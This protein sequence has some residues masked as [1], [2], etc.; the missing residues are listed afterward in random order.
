MD[1]CS[2]HSTRAAPALQ[3]PLLR[4]SCAVQVVKVDHD[5]GTTF[6]GVLTDRC[7]RIRALWGSY[8]EQR[9]GDEVEFCAGMPAALWT[10]WLNKTIQAMNAAAVGTAAGQQEA[11]VQSSLLQGMHAAKSLSA[12]SAA[13]VWYWDMLQRLQ[14]SQASPT[15]SYSG[16]CQQGA[17]LSLQ[18]P[19]SPPGTCRAGWTS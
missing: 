6:S 1:V 5:F 10:P 12:C 18:A 11:G 15:S 3:C 7:G 4:C 17:N 13:R 16:C 2:R 8:A 14:S 19:T 9:G